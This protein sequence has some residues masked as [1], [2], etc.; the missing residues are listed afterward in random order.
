MGVIQISALESYKSLHVII[1]QDLSQVVKTV[2]V[3]FA[4]GEMLTV[5]SSKCF[6]V[7]SKISDHNDP[8]SF[9]YLFLKIVIFFTILFY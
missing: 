4:N 5:H 8:K 2:N 1:L 9:Q 6:Y 7:I 3:K